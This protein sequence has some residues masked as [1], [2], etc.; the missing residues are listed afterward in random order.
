MYLIQTVFKHFKTRKYLNILRQVIF[1][2]FLVRKIIDNLRYKAFIINLTASE[3]LEIYK[4]LYG[5]PPT[6]DA[7]SNYKDYYMT[8]RF[9]AIINFVI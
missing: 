6:Q 2:E 4:K 8:F 3:I 7:E 1:Y 5:E 9:K